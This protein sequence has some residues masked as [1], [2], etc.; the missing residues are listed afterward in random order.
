MARDLYEFLENE[1]NT[2]VA[3]EISS[4]VGNLIDTL[5]EEVHGKFYGINLLRHGIVY[6]H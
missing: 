6:L 2:E 4:S 5:E 3:L 1:R